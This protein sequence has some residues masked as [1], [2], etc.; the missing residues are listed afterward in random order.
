MEF[1]ALQTAIFVIAYAIFNK[2]GLGLRYFCLFLMP[3]YAMAILGL[4]GGALSTNILPLHIFGSALII[5]FALAGKKIRKSEIIRYSLILL[6][7]LVSLVY[8]LFFF[9]PVQGWEIQGELRTSGSQLRMKDSLS[10]TNVTQL[11]Y[12]IFGMTMAC[13]YSSISLDPEKLKKTIDIMLCVTIVIGALQSASWYLGVHGQYKTIF[14][15]TNT[16]MSDQ[17]FIYGWK[18]ING[19]FQEPSYL[20]HFLFFTLSFYLLCFGYKTFIKSKLVLA[21]IILGVASTATTFY[22]GF[23]VLTIYAYL[24]YATPEQKMWYYIIGIVAIPIAAYFGLDSFYDYINAKQT[25]TDNR[26]NMGW[27]VAWDGIAK[28]PFFGLGYGTHRPL[29]IYTQFLSA[30]GIFGT[31][32]VIYAFLQGKTNSNMRHY[33]LLV[34]AI[35]IAAFEMTRHE[36]WIYFGL[37]SNP[38]IYQN[39]HNNKHKKP[40]PKQ[41]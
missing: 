10:M 24:K 30:I 29:F 32:F 38:Y 12:I 19:S 27:T 21:S 1:F 23:V 11:I 34:V 2:L 15:T 26:F 37:L 25:S 35:G 3:F 16:I 18:R 20:G 5:W 41:P 36:M 22:V 4:G 7:F 8:N 13:L 31:A 9:E 39:L 40:S 14:N 6:P 17:V 33:L 28:S